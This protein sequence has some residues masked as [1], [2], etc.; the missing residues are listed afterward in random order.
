[1]RRD[2]GIGSHVCQILFSTRITL[3]DNREIRIMEACIFFLVELF[4]CLGSM[5]LFSHDFC[6]CDY[7]GTIRSAELCSHHLA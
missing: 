3:D 7:I 1:M 6:I 5:K 4:F 2:L